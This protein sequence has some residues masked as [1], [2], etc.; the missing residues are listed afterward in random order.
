MAFLEK[1][2][3][4]S[5]MD[6]FQKWFSDAEKKMGREWAT[7]MCLSTITLEGFPDGRM[8]LLKE[9]D[10]RGFVFYTSLHSVKG[11]SLAGHPQAALTF[12]WQPL[13]RQVRIQGTAELVSDA[14]A[15]VYF[16]SRARLSQL[17]AW[18]SQQ[19][20]PLKSRFTLLRE[21]VRVAMQYPTGTIPRPPTWNGF[22]IKPLRVEFWQAGTNRL[23]DRFVYEKQSGGSWSITRLYP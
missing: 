13:E 20:Q 1:D 6:Q 12:Y 8:V 7:T 17:G 9:F 2:L 16:H 10:P 23:H 11:R 18:A 19:S 21:V 5:P 3:Q 22:R 15:D 4:A 14:E